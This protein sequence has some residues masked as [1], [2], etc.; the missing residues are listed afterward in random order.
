MVQRIN[1]SLPEWMVRDMIGNS[2]NK[3][4]RIQELMTKGYMAEVQ[5]AD[6]KPVRSAQDSEVKEDN[7]PGR[8][9]TSLFGSCLFDLSIIDPEFVGYRN[10]LLDGL[11]SDK[12]SPIAADIFVNSTGHI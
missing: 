1:V 3:S 12:K 9:N 5:K 10:Y 7:G 4:E 11:K 6:A 8:I 2:T